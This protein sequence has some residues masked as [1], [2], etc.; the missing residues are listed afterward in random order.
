M[1]PPR[2]GSASKATQKHCIHV[3]NAAIDGTRWGAPGFQRK[4]KCSS[5]Q[6]KGG[7]DMVNGGMPKGKGVPGV[8]AAPWSKAAT[9]TVLAALMGVS[10]PASAD[11]PDDAAAPSSS[12]S[13]ESQAP[14]PAGDPVHHNAARRAEDRLLELVVEYLERAFDKR[15]SADRVASRRAMPEPD[16]MAAVDTGS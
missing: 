5:T 16:R 10:G 12:P 6:L 14:A 8:R 15:S 4:Q 2:T 13:L 9:S 1:A 3:Y 11:R 7:R